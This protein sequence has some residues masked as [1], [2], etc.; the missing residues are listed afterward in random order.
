MIKVKN[1]YI[2]TFDKIKPEDREIVGVKTFDY[3]KLHNTDVNTPSA[4]SITTL[5]F[6]DFLILNNLVDPIFEQLKSVRPFI[7]KTAVEAS[8][9]ITDLILNNQFPTKIKEAL[10]DGYYS[11]GNKIS[12]PFLSIEVSS[13]VPNKYI[14]ANLH[15]IK[16]LDI[17]GVDEYLSCVIHIWLSLFTVESIEY[18]TNGYYEGP[19]STAILV[20]KIIRPEVS[21]KVYSIPPITKEE[22]TIEIYCI[23]GLSDK[24]VSLDENA[25][26]YKVN[27]QNNKIIEKNILPQDFM[28]VRKGK[29]DDTK[30]PNIVVE[31]S[32]EWQKKQKIDDKKILELTND[33]LKLEDTFKSPLEIEWGIEAGRI[34]ITDAKKMSIKTQSYDPTN[35]VD[36]KELKKL[37][38]DIHEE[39]QKPDLN[40]LEKEINEIINSDNKNLKGKKKLHL[41]LVKQKKTRNKLN[42][43]SWANQYKFI[44]DVFLEITSLDI[45]NIKSLEL[46]N[47]SYL[48]GTYFL[49][50]QKLLPEDQFISARK[51]QSLIDKI[52]IDISTAAKNTAP[53]SII[54]Q[55]SNIGES[56]LKEFN[57]DPNDFNYYGDERFINDPKT[58]SAEVISVQKVKD[59]F[60]CNNVSIC[61]PNVRNCRNL[62][63][64]KTIISKT[65]LRR[66]TNTKFYAEVSVPS[67][68]LELNSIKEDLI[69]G[70]IVNYDVLIKLSSYRNRIRKIDHDIFFNVLMDIKKNCKK[71]KLEFIVKFN[72]LDSLNINKIFDISADSYIF[73]EIPNKEI[74]NKIQKAAIDALK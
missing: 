9:N 64:I 60:N 51:T 7:R 42:I 35:E 71:K 2:N 1:S 47:G 16:F 15:K 53:N 39:T 13:T 65:G 61:V 20:K 48:D 8:K 5:A 49:L 52:A 10:I 34:F 41:E 22:D 56:E 66:S 29:F 25:D 27:I 45:Q 67:F 4:F 74:F 50:E 72:E 18:R 62:E 54:Y 40:E 6:D 37:D 38:I 23:Y 17:K 11:L 46:F 33:T 21:G 26:T 3:S 68:V 36:K 31:I 55:F 24:T 63:D 14:P 30:N 28:V 44:S 43:P 69:D 59:E 12:N 58:L 32:K 73:G 19:I 57:K 70:L